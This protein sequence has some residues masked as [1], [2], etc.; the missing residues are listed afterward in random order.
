MLTDGRITCFNSD[1]R[2]RVTSM[3]T[4]QTTAMTARRLEE[5]WQS[6][7]MQSSALATFGKTTLS[8][9]ILKFEFSKYPGFPGSYIWLRMLGH[10][11]IGQKSANFFRDLV[12][13]TNHANQL[14]SETNKHISPAENG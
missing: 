7:E 3:Q 4:S 11:E 10:E 9:S 13:Q 6:Q 8:R 1:L 2:D 12:L 14:E 5:D